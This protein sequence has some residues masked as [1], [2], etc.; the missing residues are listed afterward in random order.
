MPRISSDRA[1]LLDDYFTGHNLVSLD[2]KV[3]NDNS[4][5]PIL[6]EILPCLCVYMNLMTWG[7]K[8]NCILN[9]CTVHC[10]D[11]YVSSNDTCIG[12]SCC[13]LGLAYWIPSSRNTPV[14][15]KK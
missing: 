3:I 4:K 2:L 10:A 8:T 11:Y 5:F 14:I 12:T 7:G 9:L 15:E 6:A 1:D 13:Q